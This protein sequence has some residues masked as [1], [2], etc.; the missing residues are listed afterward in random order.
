MTSQ[1]GLPR[2][3]LRLNG[4]VWLVL[5]FVLA[6]TPR[7]TPQTLRLPSPPLQ[8]KPGPDDDVRQKMEKDMAKKANLARQADLKRDTDKLLKLA[9]ELKES[10]DKTNESTLSLDVLKKA[11]EIEKLAHSVKDKMKGPY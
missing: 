5:L 1:S 2:W 3:I 6:A 9:T 7:A 8:Q 10:V 11:E 4:L